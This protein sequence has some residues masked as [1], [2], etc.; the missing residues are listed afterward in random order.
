MKEKYYDY[1]YPYNF[2]YKLAH[3][4]VPFQ[5]LVNVYSPKQAL[6]KGTIFPELYMPYEWNKDYEK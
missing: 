3:A 4:Y 5:K 6:C 2:K 1:K